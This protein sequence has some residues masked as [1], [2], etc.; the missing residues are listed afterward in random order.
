[1]KVGGVVEL[2]LVALVHARGRSVRSPGSRGGDD[3]AVVAVDPD[4]HDRLAGGALG[5][6]RGVVS[7]IC[8]LAM[9]W[10]AIWPA[11]RPRIEGITARR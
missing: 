6:D 10:M 2:E 11:A 4:G 1:M 7:S 3:Q 8:L 9:P 5:A